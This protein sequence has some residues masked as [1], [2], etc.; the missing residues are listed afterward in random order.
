LLSAQTINSNCK[1]LIIASWVL[2]PQAA[3]GIDD[4]AGF[5]QQTL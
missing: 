2:W 1:T 5:M 3:P 4:D